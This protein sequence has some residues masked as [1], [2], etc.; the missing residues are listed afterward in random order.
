[1]EKVF[2]D[3]DI[4]LDLLAKR[5]PHYKSAALLFSQV[6]NGTIQAFISPLIF[7]NLFYILR[8]STSNARAKETLKKLKTLVHLLPINEKII[9]QALNSEFTD[10]EDAFQY[11]T[12]IENGIKILI[13][14]NKKDYK[15]AAIMMIC[16]ADEFLGSFS[17]LGG[18]S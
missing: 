12:A 9:E 4:I 11:Y 15:N 6:E 3:S 10:F 13:T 18:H 1:M 2:V 5:D 7:A 16:T 8:K 17:K 14:R